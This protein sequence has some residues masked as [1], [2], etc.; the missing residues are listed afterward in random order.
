MPEWQTYLWLIRNRIRGW[1]FQSSLLG[2]R[3][4][5][6]GVVADFLFSPPDWT[7]SMVW[8]VQGEFF[9]YESTQKQ[10]EDI[11]QR[12]TLENKGY[13]VVDILGNDIATNRDEVLNAALEGRQLFVSPFLD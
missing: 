5:L 8:R 6:G 13:V 3:I 2:G 11:F 12:V 4:F 9:H 1:D 10:I 7:P